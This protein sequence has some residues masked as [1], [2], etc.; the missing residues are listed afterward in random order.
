MLPCGLQ[1]YL[2]CFTKWHSAFLLLYFCNNPGKKESGSSSVSN[3]I[4]L[5]IEDSYIEFFRYIIGFKVSCGFFFM[6]L[7][8]GVW[9]SLFPQ[10]AVI[11]PLWFDCLPINFMGT[12][13]IHFYCPMHLK[14]TNIYSRIFASRDCVHTYV[15]THVCSISPVYLKSARNS[16]TSGWGLAHRR[17]LDLL[18]TS[19]FWHADCF[20]CS[21]ELQLVDSFLGAFSAV[22][23]KSVLMCGVT[24]V[25]VLLDWASW[26]VIKL[27]YFWREQKAKYIVMNSRRPF[28]SFLFPLPAHTPV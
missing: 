10:R 28:N 14:F 15:H 12:L 27:V 1:A 20:H 9:C 6:A 2:H 25:H 8:I 17:V 4:N 7:K 24:V 18:A 26:D 22:F 21:A 19:I 3:A 23:F 11:L 16:D 13:W 5:G